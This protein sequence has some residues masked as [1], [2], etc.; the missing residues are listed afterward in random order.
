MND[1]TPTSLVLGSGG[2]R[3]LAH[4]GVIQCLEARGYSI[5][6]VAGSSIGA[7]VGGIY[8]AGRLDAYIDWVT[9]L[10]KSDIVRLLD[11][12][13]DRGA[14]FKGERIFAVLRELIGECDIEALPIGFTAVATDVS[15]LGSGREIWFNQGPLFDAIRASSA[16]PGVFAPFK[17]DGHILVDGGVVNPVP[18][19]PTLNNRTPMTVAVDLNGLSDPERTLSGAASEDSSNGSLR[20]VYQQS[21]GRYLDKLWPTPAPRSNPEQMGFSEMLSRSMET[22]Q[23]SITNFKLAAN[24]PTVVV[25]IPRDICGFFDFH[26]AEE[27]IAFGYAC[28][29]RTIDQQPRSET[30]FSLSSGS[31]VKC[32][33]YPSQ[34][35]SP[36]GPLET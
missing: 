21:V 6:M 10:H 14:L 15:A 24:T 20:T 28:A 31:D 34:N 36:H 22:M 17:K 29:E 3:G 8:A 30:V 1:N 33:A 35:S 32:T 11:W 27:L 9:A 13:F 25:R 7:L 19:G 26:R 18:V 23:A 4:I 2:A 16:I 12:S 5:Q